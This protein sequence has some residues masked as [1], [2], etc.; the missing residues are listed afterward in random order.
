LLWRKQRPI[1]DA[2]FA[3]VMN[4]AA[5][6]LK[7]GTEHDIRNGSLLVWESFWD[8]S[9][10]LHPGSFAMIYVVH[11]NLILKRCCAQRL[12]IQIAGK[13]LSDSLALPCLAWLE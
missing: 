11:T 3:G 2:L 10:N 7:L 1:H 12:R 8:R 13:V 4:E 6:V 5:I 9:R